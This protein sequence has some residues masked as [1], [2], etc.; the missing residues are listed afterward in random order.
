MSVPNTRSPWRKFWGGKERTPLV[1]A[2]K[3]FEAIPT[4]DRNRDNRQKLLDIIKNEFC[5][6]QFD[7]SYSK[8]NL[9]DYAVQTM[10]VNIATA[11]FTQYANCYQTDKT[12]LCTLFKESKE[13]FYEH[14]EKHNI[15]QQVRDKFINDLNTRIN[16]M[17]SCTIKPTVP[18]Q[19]TG[20]GYQSASLTTGFLF[21]GRRTRHKKRRN[22]RRTRSRV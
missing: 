17:L 20:T 13:S 2:F 18:E 19:P 7:D 10:D 4:Y 14:A 11:A 8:K 3:E 1:Q 5:T 9:I 6:T 21:G 16:T 15:N 12:E 22:K